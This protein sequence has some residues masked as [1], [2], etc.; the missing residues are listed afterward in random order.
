MSEKEKQP[1]TRGIDIEEL[2]SEL[3][4]FGKHYFLG[5]GIDAYENFEPLNN[6]VKD[7]KDISSILK[8][9]YQFTESEMFLL[10]N[11]E[12]NEKNILDQPG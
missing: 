4:I 7:V 9:K 8:E 6:A 1:K 3:K 11:E 10:L 5:I 2:D 12:A